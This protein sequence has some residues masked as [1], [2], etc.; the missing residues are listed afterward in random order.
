MTRPLEDYYERELA[1]YAE[2][3]RDFARR[4]PAEAGRLIPEA[5]RPIDPH[6]ERFI[7]GFALLAG[8]M[9]HKLDSEF[10][11]LTESLLQVLYPHFLTPVP[12][13]S[14]AQFG[15]DLEIPGIKDGK[16][17]PKHTGL[18]TRPLGPEGQPLLPCRWRTGYPVT[19][20]PIRLASAQ[21]L[22]SF[23]PA[24][25]PTPP[26]TLA[27][28]VLQ[29]ECLGPWKFSDLP[30]ETLRFYLSGD[31]Q[32]LAN[33]YEVLFN[34][35]LQVAFRSLD[36]DGSRE[37]VTYAPG[38]CLSQV[39][40][41]EDEGLLPFPSESF[42]GY[43]ILTEF[44]SFR[45]KFMFVDL[46]GFRQAR[47]AGFGKK[48]EVV[49]FL[50]RAEVNLEQGVTP[51]T[52]L[53]GCTPIVNVFPKSAEPLAVTQRATEYRVVPSRTQ[54]MSMEVLSVE[55]V[56]AL[57]PARTGRPLVNFVPFYEFHWGSPQDGYAFWHQTRRESFV[58]GDLGTEVYLTLVDS[59]F[60]PHVP[61]NAVLHVKTTCSN[62]DW[63]VR[64]QR[65]GEAL[66]LEDGAT[67]PGP[68]TCL[69]LPTMPLRPPLRQSTYWRLLA[70]NNLNQISLTHP[71]EGRQA[72]QEILRL[73]DFT[74]YRTVPQLAAV[75]QQVISGIVGL[76]TRRVMG[77]I[78]EGS[79]IGFCRGV[80][81]M[82]EFDER[83]Y[84]GVGLYVFACVLERFL[85]QYAA[86]NSFS[87]LIAK[88]KQSEVYFKKWPP[89]AASRQLQ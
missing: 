10:P 48:I 56:T 22:R 46:S 88:T 63:P 11:E 80:E 59:E 1:G 82:L 24:G 42:L 62:R 4:Y 87:Q 37:I 52:F 26:R 60:S 17:I 43:R 6:L 55:S 57:D 31:R 30:L 14:I 70:Q 32:V 89:R 15:L 79:E 47:E 9:H 76:K 38:E 74:D 28:L 44:L 85:G 19:L 75:N 33:L 20:W 54:P 64:F 40:F 34:H 61:A 49:F 12:S 36:A 23:F 7:E 65:G 41:E 16:V 51:R 78:S 77:R 5:G 2:V 69:Q 45:E 50:N 68:I 27:A 21:V 72:L 71:K 83:D 67:P 25:V 81:I 39:G 3:V 58:H 8:R 18:R 86:V 73:C 66:F 13:M 29:L 84:V 35:T 53:L